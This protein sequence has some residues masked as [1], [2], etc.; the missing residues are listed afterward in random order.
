[1]SPPPPAVFVRYRLWDFCAREYTAVH[2]RVL[3]AALAPFRCVYD[4]YEVNEKGGQGKL[5]MLDRHVKNTGQI[6]RK[7]VPQAA[8]AWRKNFHSASD[9]PAM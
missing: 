7:H 6:A 3:A 8:L 5:H 1:M 2:R 9:G 4:V